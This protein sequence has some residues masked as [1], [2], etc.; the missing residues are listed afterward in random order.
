MK[1]NFPYSWSALKFQPVDISNIN[2]A[3]QARLLEMT[4]ARM[5]IS[6][7]VMMVIII[8]FLWTHIQQNNIATLVFWSIFYLILIFVVWYPYNQFLRDSHT[9]DKSPFLIKWNQKIETIAILHGAGLS[10]SVLMAFNLNHYAF[11]VLILI[12]AGHL[13]L[14]DVKYSSTFIG[15]FLRYLSIGCNPVLLLIPWVFPKEWMIIMPLILL[16]SLLIYRHSTKAIQFNVNQILLEQAHQ[17]LAENYRLAKVDAEQALN[18]KIQFLTTASHDLRQPVHAMGF[19]I[20]SIARQNQDSTIEPALKDLRQS[21]RSVTQMFNSLLDLSKIESGKV[22]LHAGNIYLDALI[23]E[24]AIVFAEEAR[25]KN[26][27]IRTRVS[28]GHAITH[29]DGTL[30]HQSIMNLM[31]NALRYTKKGGVLI[32]VRKRAN[33]WMIEVWDTGVGVAIEDQDHIYSPFYRN[34]HAWRIDS[35]GHGLGLS[36]VARCCELMECQYGFS[37]RLGRGSRFWLRLP[38]VTGRLQSI[39]IINE[40]KHNVLPFAHGA[41]SGTCLVVDD[42]PQVTNA[43]ESLLSSWGVTAQCVESGEQALAALNNGFVPQV[44]FCDQRLRAGESGFDILREL[45]TRCSP[46][47]GAMISGEFD[48]PE[49]KQAENEGFLV[50]H[51]PLEPDQLYTV[52]SRWLNSI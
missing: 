17:A 27:E 1:I 41:L 43:W 44:I 33:E 51:K 6:T 4:Y 30:L 5:R 47:I 23:K 16:Y 21:V 37:S 20:E 32:A 7:S 35:A 2:L 14:I 26:I 11:L 52:L 50:L 40:L 22:E 34:E 45:L 9:L 15:S 13:Q 19:L 29:T 36:V 48:S 38:A 49:L 18:S 31:H 46:A 39:P 8:P 25:T 24:I 3:G 10:L 42:D 12:V 28:K